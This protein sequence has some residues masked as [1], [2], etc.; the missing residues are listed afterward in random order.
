[1][2]GYIIHRSTLNAN[3]SISRPNYNTLFSRSGAQIYY[4]EVRDEG[5]GQTRDNVV[6]YTYLRLELEQRVSRAF[7]KKP[8][9]PVFPIYPGLYL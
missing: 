9:S 8:Y 7:D 4:L 2:R 5:S 3:Q 1:M 6:G